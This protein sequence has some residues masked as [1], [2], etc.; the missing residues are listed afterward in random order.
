M[1]KLNVLITGLVNSCTETFK[2]TNLDLDWLF[3]NPST[4]LWADKIFFTNHVKDSL[5]Q[6]DETPLDKSLNLIFETLEDNKIIKFK[7]SDNIYNDKVSEKVWGQISSDLSRIHDE[8]GSKINIDENLGNDYR[9]IFL[10]GK[11]YCGTELMSIYASLIISE[12]WNAKCLFSD[13]ALNFLKYKLDFLPNEKVQSMQTSFNNVF[14]L[15]VPDLPLIHDYSIS[16]SCNSCV[17]EQRCG[18]EYLDIIEDNLQ[19]YI[20]LREF[21][22]IKQIKDVL[23]DLN[24]EINF[25]DH[26]IE[27]DLLLKEYQEKRYQIYKKMHTKFPKIRKWS[28]Y[29]FILF[30]SATIGGLMSGSALLTSL[31]V[32][33]DVISGAVKFGLNHVEDNN[34]WI[35]FKVENDFMGGKNEF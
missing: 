1:S 11:P 16:E 32:G 26:L 33:I 9:N 4:L 18:L 28:N 13:R 3:Y 15:H 25:N 19:K 27:D 23:Q 7:N 31:G 10:E 6:R 2:I 30:S 20:D 8:Y 14:K 35:G 17:H 34:K 22:E 12:K 24:D 5:F 29:S 21:D